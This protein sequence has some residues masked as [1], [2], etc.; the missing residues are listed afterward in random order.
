[1]KKV[2]YRE[3]PLKKEVDGQETG[4]FSIILS[5]LG[6]WIS[7]AKFMLYDKMD[8]LSAFKAVVVRFYILFFVIWFALC[9]IYS[10]IR[11]Q[12]AIKKRDKILK[13]GKKYPAKVI[14]TKYITGYRFISSGV[15]YVVEYQDDYGV[16]RK[17][18]TPKMDRTKYAPCVPDYNIYILGK[19]KYVSD[20]VVGIDKRSNGT[21]IDNMMKLPQEERM[22][23]E[24]FVNKYL[25]PKLAY[26]KYMNYKKLEADPEF[27]KEE[28]EIK[29]E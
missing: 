8:Y 9:G 20:Y 22:A 4:L 7:I 10:L 17:F 29:D 21:Y 14:K 5:C 16:M 11:S 15:K 12:L 26:E 6:F 27:G 1:M 18:T 23:Y 2:D 24:Y 13:Y 3:L 25:D 28:E 19:S